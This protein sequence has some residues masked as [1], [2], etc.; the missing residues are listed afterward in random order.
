MDRILHWA[1]Q[2]HG[3]WRSISTGLSLD[4]HGGWPPHP[5]QRSGGCS[6]IIEEREVG[7]SRQHASTIGPSRWRGC[8]HR[9]HDN[10]QQDLAD[11]RMANPM[12]PVLS[13]DTSQ[14]RQPVAVPELPNNKPHQSPKQNHA[15]NYTE[16]IEAT[17]CKDHRWRTGR[18]PSRKEHHRA[19]LQPEILC[20]KY[21]QH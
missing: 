14:E 4:R 8:N 12:D 5:W 11:R 7:W 15:E 9:S 16:Q 3:Q 2:S 13:Y 19:D 20:E 17:S 21:L 1:V 18:L 6:T 10:L